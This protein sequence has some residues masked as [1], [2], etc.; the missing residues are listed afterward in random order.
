MTTRSLSRAANGLEIDSA[1][2][3]RKVGLMIWECIPVMT[4]PYCILFHCLHLIWTSKSAGV[5]PTKYRVIAHCKNE[6]LL[7]PD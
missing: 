1:I 4:F 7:A 3:I 6:V 5:S 2:A